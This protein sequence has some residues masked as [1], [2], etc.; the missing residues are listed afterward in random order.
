MKRRTL[1]PHVGSDV[2]AALGGNCPMAKAQVRVGIVLVSFT[3]LKLR[4]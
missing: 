1:G 2:A 4:S 3:D